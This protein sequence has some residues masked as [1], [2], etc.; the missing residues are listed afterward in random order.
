MIFRISLTFDYNKEGKVIIPCKYDDLG[1][2]MD[3]LALV[4]KNNK[5]GYINKEGK[6]VIPFQ[7]DDASSFRNNIAIVQQDHYLSVIN[8]QGKILFDFPRIYKSRY[9]LGWL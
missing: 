6:I 2:F 5:Y 9:I 3:G 7:Y 1:G 4:K 8:T